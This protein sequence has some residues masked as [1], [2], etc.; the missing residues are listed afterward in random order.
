MKNFSNHHSALRKGTGEILF[1][2]FYVEETY[3]IKRVRFDIITNSGV[4]PF[5][6]HGRR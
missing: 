6:L 2:F 5:I 1:F 3:L 4:A